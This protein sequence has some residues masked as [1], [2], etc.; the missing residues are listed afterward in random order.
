MLTEID[1]LVTISLLNADGWPLPGKDL[2][3]IHYV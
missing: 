2:S 3:T 1:K